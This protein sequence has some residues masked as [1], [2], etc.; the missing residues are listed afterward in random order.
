MV[1]VSDNSSWLA[2][3]SRRS[4]RAV[5]NDIAKEKVSPLLNV[6]APFN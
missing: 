5:P 6:N 3:R 1:N 4:K 2:Q